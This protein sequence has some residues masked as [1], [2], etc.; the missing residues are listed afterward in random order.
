MGTLPMAPTEQVQSNL[1]SCFDERAT[2]RLIA[3]STAKYAFMNLIINAIP[4]AMRIE[5][6][7]SFMA[8]P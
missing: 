8:S 1:I 7:E 3:T 6:L 5:S 2:K 4:F